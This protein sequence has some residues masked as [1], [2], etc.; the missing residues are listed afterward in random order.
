[1]GISDINPVIILLVSKSFSAFQASTSFVFFLRQ[2]WVLSRPSSILY[3][4]T[5]RASTRTNR[6]LYSKCGASARTAISILSGASSSPTLANF[7]LSIT[8]RCEVSN[9]SENHGQRNL[10]LQRVNFYFAFIHHQLYQ[11]QILLKQLMNFN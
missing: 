2:L 3:S 1:M 10:F 11:Q 8:S 5:L 7:V 9:S 4:S 6:F